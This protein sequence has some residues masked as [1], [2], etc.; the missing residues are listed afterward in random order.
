MISKVFVSRPKFAFVISIFLTLTGLLAIPFLPVS[1]FPDLAPPQI[2]V[3]T[4]YPGASA[5]IVKDVVAQVIETEVNGV[6]GML[7]MSS[8]SANDGSYALNVTFNVGTD[9]DMAQVNVSNRV[10]KAMANLPDEI[11]RQGV[12][13]EKQSPNLL[14]AVNLFSPSGR[15]DNLFLNN[16][17][18]I[19]IKNNLARV[20]G[21]SKVNIIGAMDYSMRLWLDPNKMASLSITV[22]DVM[23]AIKEQNIQVA[24][25]RIGAAP[26]NKEQRF[27]Y[28]LKTKGRLSDPEEFKNIVLRAETDA[29]IVLL[30]DVARVELGALSYDAAGFLNGK[31][32]ALLFINQSSDANALDVASGVKEE[33]EKL[34]QSFP[35]GLEY[36]VLY[37]TTEFVDAS[38][39]EMY[40]TLFIAV[41]LVILVVY[42]FLQN[43]RQTLIPAIAIP[44]SL[45]GTFLFLLIFNLSLNTVTLFALVLAIGI[46]VDDAIV[47]VENV[48]RH[49]NDGLAPKE[50]TLKT[51]GEVSGPVIATTLVLLAVFAPTAVMPGITGKMYAQFSV[52]ICIA[53][54]I[55]SINALTLSPALCSTL[56]KK[57]DGHTKSWFKTTFNNGF[58]KLTENYSLLVSVLLKKVI[59]VATMFAM[60]LVFLW[61]AGANIPSSFV[62][63]EDKKAIFVDISLPDGASLNRTDKQ[64]QNMLKEIKTLD[65]VS[66][67][68]S[69]SGYSIVSET[70]SSNAGLMI[71]LLDDWNDRQSSQLHERTIVQKI[72]HLLNRQFPGAQALAFSLPPLPGVGTVGGAEFNLQNTNGDTPEEL[73]IVMSGFITNLNSQSEISHAYS[74]YRANVPQ[75]FVEVDRIKAK[76][77]GIPLNEIFVSLQTML[78]GSY[79]NDFNRYGKVFRVMVQADSQFRNSEDDIISFHVRNKTGEMVPLSTLVD[80]KPVLGPE[81]IGQFNLYTSA[82][83]NAFPAS[84]YSSGEVINAIERAVKQL[85]NGYSI[86]WSGQ[87]YQ[88]IEAGNL[89]PI[90]FSLA[91]VFTY[92]FLVAQYESWSI[93]F[94]IIL[95]V[96]IAILGAFITL[97]IV[98]SDMNLYAQIGMVLLIGMACKNAILVV[99]FACQLR[100]SGY[101]IYDAALNAAKLR[102]RAVL[103]TAVSFI[104]GIMPLVF[105][106][107]AGAASRQSLGYVIFGGMLAAS[108]VGTILVPVLYFVIQNIREKLNKTEST[109]NITS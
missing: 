8:K 47:V 56:L 107:G 90:I 25:G 57:E 66:D 43:I 9:A 106:S 101:S 38:I 83:I 82:Q 14:M 99:E 104:L 108:I 93:P 74:G 76:S 86:S 5:E 81:Y 85:P 12:S 98:G 87:T 88:E 105:A 1:E 92:L 29:S 53:V 95:S 28:T 63:Q 30:G 18:G 52:T 109:S 91:L 77:Q 44:V 80:V 103:M 96:P 40:E 58:D 2:N 68:I 4:S 48:T 61:F 31:D 3:N 45:I 41:A 50:A 65:G 72:N 37:D 20:N 49:I 73:A 69:A 17:M 23:Q 67:I 89:A 6:E 21:V 55:S 33:L 19:Y 7:Y 36:T 62:P 60:L 24:A 10:Q 35:E 32:S 11:K 51:M 100:D 54:I 16:Y 39:E 34:A 70:V 97:I 22:N 42:L 84:G 15:Y 59:F 13:V 46:V 27:Q 102:F 71:V 94:A 75:M 78:G 26:V 64:L 79:I